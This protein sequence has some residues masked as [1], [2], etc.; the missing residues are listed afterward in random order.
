MS[1]VSAGASAAPDQRPS[2]SPPPA[3]PVSWLARIFLGRRPPLAQAAIGVFALALAT[4]IRFALDPVLPPGLPFLTFFPAVLV[5]AVFASAQAGALVALGGGLLAWTFFLGPEG[6]IWARSHGILALGFYAAVTATELFFISAARTALA[7]TETARATAN[8]LARSRDLM[9]SELQHRV[10]NNLATI[11]A[12]LRVQ[13]H[14]L[15]NPEAKQALTSAMQRLNTVARIQR[16]LH[17]PDRQ[18]IG[19]RDLLDQLARDTVESFAATEAVELTV[20][21]AP[22]CLPQ[23]QAV[24]FGLVASELM[25]NALEHGRPANGPARLAISCTVEDGPVITLRLR[26]NGGG[27]PEGFEIGPASGLGMT[28]AAQFARQLQ[29]SLT[30]AARE[31]GPGTIATLRFPAAHG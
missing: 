1:E 25:M 2:A 24:P 4:G 11:G 29:G 7:E 19:L 26:D 9:F 27:L 18:S 21:C 5:T 16:S 3:R 15:A 13:S 14:A 12:V 30:L 17:S 22:L 28:I 23:D 8:A 20:D 31:D 6:T 10:S